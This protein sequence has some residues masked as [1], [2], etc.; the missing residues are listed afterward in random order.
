MEE[1]NTVVIANAMEAKKKK[2]ET[3]WYA[4]RVRSPDGVISVTLSIIMKKDYIEAGAR[5]FRQ[6]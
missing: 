3:S 6:A 4:C 2:I 1:K 5:I